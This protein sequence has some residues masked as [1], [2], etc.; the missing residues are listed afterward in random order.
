MC[1]G[2]GEIQDEGRATYSF[3]VVTSTPAATHVESVEFQPHSG[4]K[5]LAPHTTDPHCCASANK[6]PVVVSSTIVNANDATDVVGTAIGVNRRRPRCMFV[7]E[8]WWAEAV[9]DRAGTRSTTILQYV[10]ATRLHHALTQ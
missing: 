10:S 8:S 2:V 4:P 3:G 6:T 9:V 7:T 5:H 1:G